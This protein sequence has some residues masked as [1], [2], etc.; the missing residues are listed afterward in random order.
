MK[1]DKIKQLAKKLVGKSYNYDII[2]NCIY[3]FKIFFTTRKNKKCLLFDYKN[4]INNKK[5]FCHEYYRG[6]FYY[7]ISKILKDYSDYNKKIPCCIEH[8]IYFGNFINEYETIYND[9]PGIITFGETRKK[10]I[11]DN[12]YKKNIFEIGP[13]IYYANELYSSEEQ[14]KLKQ[15]YGKTL[16]VFPS[17]SVD[18]VSTVFDCNLFINKIKK[19]KKEYNFDTVIVSLYYRDI[20]LG[21]DQKYVDAGFKV[22]S[23]GRRED[24]NFLNRLKSF[25]NISDYTI[26]NSV[27][28]HIGYCIFLGKPHMV[29]SQIINYDIKDGYY[30]SIENTFMSSSIKQKNEIISC[31]SDYT[32]AIT[33]RQYDVCEKYWG[34]SKVKSK[35]E[36]LNI[37]KNMEIEMKN[38]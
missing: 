19:F 26:S 21:H 24:Y 36:L 13:Y 12:N 31:F 30:S 23:A 28:T 17:H 3:N 34:F 10:I 32:E 2:K 16:L 15:I 33:K 29:F 5:F 37:L 35:Q 18:K 4:I 7:G 25:I 1:K 38:N 9:L 14:I 8:G 6:N 22:V 20:E 11:R 27:G